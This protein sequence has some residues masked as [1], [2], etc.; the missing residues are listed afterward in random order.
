MPQ[1]LALI[2]SVPV[3][4]PLL[5]NSKIT[6]VL[7]IGYN[8]RGIRAKVFDRDAVLRGRNSG[9]CADNKIPKIRR[10][11]KPPSERLNR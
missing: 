2:D 5:R 10:V 11:S 7:Q 4:A 6:R 3:A 1:G 9:E 8:P